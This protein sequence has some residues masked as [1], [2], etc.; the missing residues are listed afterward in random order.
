MVPEDRPKS[1]WQRHLDGWQAGVVV[2]V[3]AGCAVLTA[4]PRAVVPQQI[5]APRIDYAALHAGMQRDAALA[6]KA[7]QTRLDVAVRQVGRQLRLYNIAAAT[8]RAQE[9]QTAK[10]RLARAVLRALPLGDEPLLQLRAYQLRQFTTAALAWQR[11]TP[12]T[13]DLLELGG[14][15]VM[16]AQR[17]GWFDAEGKLLLQERQLHALFKQ[18]WNRITGVR[19]PA[20]ELS[21]AEDLVRFDF[22]LVHPFIKHK[23]AALTHSVRGELR[24]RELAR[25]R[26]IDHL[27]Q[28]DPSYHA[29]LARGVVMY[30]LG[31]Y[32]LAAQHFRTQL[33]QR[34]D[35]PFTL[36]AQNYLKASLDALIGGAP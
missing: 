22:L 32:A 5:P 2:V 21:L 28:R 25:L 7:E 6:R 27:A 20:F 15:F 34:P 23:M 4:V 8:D 19:K 16:A 26:L 1:F 30:R 14:D 18:R 12:P 24:Q 17:S 9:L 10:R 35:G 13:K 29:S 3:I 11:D 36:Y 31:Q 33:T